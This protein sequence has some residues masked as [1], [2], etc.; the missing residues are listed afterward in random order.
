MATKTIPEPGCRAV[1]ALA[2]AVRALLLSPPRRM[3][4]SSP[5][6]Q[7][8]N[9]RVDVVGARATLWIMATSTIPVGWVLPPPM[10]PI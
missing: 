4:G 2:T 8:G 1:M 5:F 9:D 3:W 10:V 6:D 7:A